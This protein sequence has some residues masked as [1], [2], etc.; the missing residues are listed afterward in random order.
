MPTNCSKLFYKRFTL[1]GACHVSLDRMS[2]RT[3]GEKIQ[4]TRCNLPE[5][6]EHHSIS[7]TIRR[8]KVYLV[9]PAPR[10]LYY[11][12]CLSGVLK[13]PATKTRETGSAGQ[14]LIAR[15]RVF[16]LSG[17]PSST[18]FSFSLVAMLGEWMLL[19]FDWAF[20]SVRISGD[21]AI[22]L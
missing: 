19:D 7:I 15:T 20:L 2:T 5:L 8:S 16:S 3:R 10:W 17:T 12:H 6:A 21:W 9:Y 14:P 11:G 4:W 22:I 18:W 13:V 1:T